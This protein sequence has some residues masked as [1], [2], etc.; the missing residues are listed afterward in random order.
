MQHQHFKEINSTQDEILKFKDSKESYILISCEKQLA[1]RGQ[2]DRTW[3]SYDGTL[4]FSFKCLENPTP[5]ITS[6]E[7]SVIL[8]N[9]F[10][11]RY[12]IEIKVKWPN[13]IYKDG[14][15][16]MG[17]LTQSLSPNYYAVGIGINYFLPPN[18]DQFGSLL[19]EVKIDKE[20]ESLEIYNFINLNRMDSHD[21]VRKWEENCIHLGKQVNLKDK[22][23]STEGIFI[24]LGKYGEAL[25]ESNGLIVPAYTGSLI[26]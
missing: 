24:G 6:L 9:Y 22:S 25:I 14:K 26:F 4:C 7:L 17:I 5:S 16:V 1:G 19:S 21:V 12:N 11:E 15:K 13:D 18:E 20:Q 3:E 2:Y 23:K 8:L 10:K